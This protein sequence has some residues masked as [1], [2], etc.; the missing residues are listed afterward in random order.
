MVEP[1]WTEIMSVAAV[2]VSLA[3]IIV[4]VATGRYLQKRQHRFELLATC[5]DDLSE[6]QKKANQLV[7]WEVLGDYDEEHTAWSHYQ[8]ALEIYGLMKHHLADTAALE[9]QVN[10]VEDFRSRFR[11]GERRTP[12]GEWDL[13][14]ALAME[15]ATF[16]SLLKDAVAKALYG[17]D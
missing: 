6:R 11:R 10:R 13:S 5:L 12:N 17:T 8:S 15:A 14:D 7:Q 4:S 9:G 3:A 2:V 16:V 1:S